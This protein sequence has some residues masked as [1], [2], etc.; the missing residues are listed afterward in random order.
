MSPKLLLKDY[1]YIKDF[2]FIVER[3]IHESTEIV[4]SH[5]HDFCELVI[6]Q[7]GHGY[8][9]LDNSEIPITSG[10]V[11][12]VTPHNMHSYTKFN[13][14]T[15]LN[16]MFSPK[17]LFKN[18]WDLRDLPGFQMLF[19]LHPKMKPEMKKTGA[20]YIDGITLA[21]VVEICDKI[22]NE[23]N[24]KKLGCKAAMISYF[25]ELLILLS[26]KC[27]SA[28]GKSYDH[29]FQISRIIGYF[30]KNYSRK[31]TLEE[32]AKIS[33]MS[34]ST[35]RRRFTEVTGI[36]PI[37]YL[38]KLRLEKSIT[39]LISTHM[40]ITDI[41]FNTGFEDSNYFARQFH[42]FTGFTPSKLR[43][44]GDNLRCMVNA[45]SKN[46]TGNNEHLNNL[47]RRSF[48]KIIE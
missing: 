17:I 34:K 12:V 40:S 11:F 47:F 42:K 14:L 22:L 6:V 15:L 28:H 21:K 35:M 44:Q 36:S 32:L 16:I 37:D 9:I 7:E 5:E 3:R 13:H 33:N 26:R 24:R 31:I 38:L 48:K 2:P 43:K 46:I 45:E 18:E 8:H 30:E 20:L 27:K 19:H 10:N 41:A 23:I 1:D 29:T 39:L 4:S 25:L